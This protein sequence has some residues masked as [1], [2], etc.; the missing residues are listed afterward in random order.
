MI[1]PEGVEGT[2]PADDAVNNV[3]FSEQQLGKIASILSGDPGN[4]GSYLTELVIRV[5]LMIDG[6]R[7]SAVH[8][9]NSSRLI[10]ESFS[11]RC[12]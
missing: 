5:V 2:A 8:I 11:G 3:P 9:I 10:S 12:L 1:D 6:R 4:E 7:Q